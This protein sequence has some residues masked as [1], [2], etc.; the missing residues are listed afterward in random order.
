MFIPKK[1]IFFAAVIFTIKKYKYEKENL[2]TGKLGQVQ[3]V[4]D[5]SQLP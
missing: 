3:K 5:A 4:C 1:S 2:K